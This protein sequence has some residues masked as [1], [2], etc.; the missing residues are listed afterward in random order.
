MFSILGMG[1]RSEREV[2][3]YSLSNFFSAALG[4]PPAL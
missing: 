4:E 1:F 2:V 3:N